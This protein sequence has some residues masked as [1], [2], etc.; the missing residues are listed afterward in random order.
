MYPSSHL[1]WDSRKVS[2]LVCSF[3]YL[4]LPHQPGVV[5]HDV[6]PPVRPHGYVDQPLHLVIVLL[7]V[8]DVATVVRSGAQRHVLPASEHI[9]RRSAAG[10]LLQPFGV[11]SPLGLDGGG[12][13]LRERRPG[14][15]RFRKPH[16]LLSGHHVTA[17]QPIQMPQQQAPKRAYFSARPF[18]LK[19]QERDPPVRSPL[20]IDPL[21]R[22]LVVGDQNP[23]FDESFL[24]D[25]VVVHSP[26]FVI[27]GKDIV[28]LLTEPMRHVG[29]GA[30]IH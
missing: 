7:L 26:S 8:K 16:S 30:F 17:R 14:G 4:Q 3:D 5:D 12:S 13:A 11:P 1:F 20:T 25:R 9:F 27:D 24:D 28:P 6:D 2:A 19:T 10:H 23:L 18:V 22:T 21:S 29:A 15:L